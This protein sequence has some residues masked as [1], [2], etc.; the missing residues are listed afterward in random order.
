MAIG[1]GATWDESQPTDAVLVN[2]VDDHIR[3]LRVGVRSRMTR[4]H[5]WPASQ[6]AT[7]EAGVHKFITLQNQTASPTLSGTQV[8][9]LYTK[10]VG[11]TNQELFFARTGSGAGEL[12]ISSGTQLNLPTIFGT[13][14]TLDFNTIY[15]ATRDGFLFGYASFNGAA[16]SGGLNIV[17]D[18]ATTPTTIL[19]YISGNYLTG[20]YIS[21]HA[22]IKNGHYYKLNLI[23]GSPTT[24]GAFFQPVGW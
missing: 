23:Q 9:G 11:S 5:E 12:Q 17:S 24:T 10:V 13:R 20:G 3:D 16:N 21:V 19:Q 7:S 1:D 2:I 18:A 8:G 4:E 15:Q 22:P 6:S 14:F